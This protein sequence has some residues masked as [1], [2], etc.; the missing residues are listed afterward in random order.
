MR[1]QAR[2]IEAVFAGKNVK[3]TVYAGDHVMGRIYFSRERH[4]GGRWGDHGYG[5]GAW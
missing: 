5:A 3:I 2:S 1:H 4:T